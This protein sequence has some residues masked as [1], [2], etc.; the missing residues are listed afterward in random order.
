MHLLIR[1]IRN[2]FSSLNK[3]THEKSERIA[4][5]VLKLKAVECFVKISIWDDTGIKEEYWMIL[6]KRCL[7]RH[8]N[9]NMF[10]EYS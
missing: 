8:L 6:N 1:E 4:T 2:W 9:F 7:L 10:D 3:D 5:A